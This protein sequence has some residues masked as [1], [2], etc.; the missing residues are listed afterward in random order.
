VNSNGGKIQWYRAMTLNSLKKHAN[1]FKVYPRGQ[2]TG[3]E[4]RRECGIDD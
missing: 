4:E 1:S 3:P 2:A